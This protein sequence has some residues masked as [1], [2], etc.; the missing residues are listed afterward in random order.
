MGRSVCSFL[1]Y[2]FVRFPISS[3]GQCL[4]KLT[5]NSDNPR[6][7]KGLDRIMREIFFSLF[8]EVACYQAPLVRFDKR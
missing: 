4:Y 1:E 3:P 5:V 7:K 6:L 8:D 2:T